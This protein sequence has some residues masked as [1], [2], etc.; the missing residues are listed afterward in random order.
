MSL[1]VSTGSIQL[2][3]VRH[4]ECQLGDLVAI[5]TND[6]LVK[7]LQLGNHGD[8]TVAVTV[9]KQTVQPRGHGGSHGDAFFC[10][11]FKDFNLL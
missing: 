8:A 10:A 11:S 7:S 9:L 4:R 2:E 3:G 6:F 5:G 1:P